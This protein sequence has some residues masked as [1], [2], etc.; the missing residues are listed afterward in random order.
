MDNE[1]KNNGSIYHKQINKYH[2]SQTY[3]GEDVKQV[4]V[5]GRRVKPFKRPFHCRNDNWLVRFS[6]PV[7]T[8]DN[9]CI[10]VE[11]VTWDHHTIEE[12]RGDKGFIDKWEVGYIMRSK[13]VTFQKPKINEF[14]LL[15][16]SINRRVQEGIK[17]WSSKHVEKKAWKQTFDSEILRNYGMLATWFTE[18]KE[19]HI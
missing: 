3:D 19:V 17:W 12:K 7:K 1:I 11:R 13:A 16:M 4:E 18:N 9:R 15:F 6:E 5:N 10:R 14:F 8:V 2:Q